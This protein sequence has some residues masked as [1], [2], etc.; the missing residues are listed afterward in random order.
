MIARCIPFLHEGITKS[1]I[2]FRKAINMSTSNKLFLAA[3]ILSIVAIAYM[4]PFPSSS[5]TIDEW[6]IFP[7]EP[8]VSDYLS[9]P[10]VLLLCSVALII[11]GIKLG[12]R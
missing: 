6:T 5:K 2:F 10:L 9:L 4:P 8:P 12:R 11:A 3:L 1:G 7:Y